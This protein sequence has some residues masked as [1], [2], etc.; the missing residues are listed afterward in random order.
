[1]KI[2]VGVIFGGKSVEHEIS[3]ISAIQAINAID[4]TEYEVIP[5]YLSKDG[6]WYSG[7]VLKEVENY[8][9]QPR[10]LAQCQKILPSVNSGEHTLFT[11][12]QS[13][14]QK[15]V[16]EKIDVAFPVMHGTYGE[17]GILQG[18]LEMMNIPYV[19]C[20]VLSSAIGM[21]KITQKM[22]FQ[23]FGLAGV[24]WTSFYSKE[25]MSERK[26]V[27]ERIEKILPYPLIVKPAA[28]GSSIGVD[29]ANNREELET[30]IEAA[31]TISQRILVEEAI[32]ALKE[33][34][35]SVLGDYERTEASVCEE[36]I[37]R[38][39]FLSFEDKYISGSSSKGMSG[40]KRKLP[41]DIPEKTAESVRQMAQQAFQALQ[42]HG[43][44]RVD[45]LL[46]TQREKIFVNEV[47]TIP[48]S[49]AFYLW[50]AS[51]KSFKDLTSEL[52]ALALKRHREKNSVIFSYES[53]ILAGYQG[54]KGL[55]K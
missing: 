13:L 33:I 15:R 55:K 29:K 3:I 8:T 24:E 25:W 5:I 12:P 19:G 11:Y 41:A 20:D 10:L 22:V 21:D 45:F 1:M 16:F 17:D 26:G 23:S 14:F 36:P 32:T 48:G 42:C 49:L 50:E 4:E 52:I 35:C 28:L 37:G 31:R 39:E 18:V 51:G 44:V 27:L 43:V 53:N 30:A 7:E 47:N 38:L 40:A 6:I 9:D 46:D 54:T 2:T 34:N